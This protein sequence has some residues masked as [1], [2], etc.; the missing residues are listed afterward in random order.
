[1]SQIKFILMCTL[2]F[3]LLSCAETTIHTT[4]PPAALNMNARVAVVSFVNHSEIPLAGEQA[5]TVAA[6]ALSVRGF[7]HVLVS[8]MSEQHHKPP[9][10]KEKARPYKEQLQWARHVGAKY[11]LIGNIKAWDYLAILG[12]KPLI[13]VTLQLIDVAS[14]RTVWTADGSKRGEPRIAVAALTAELIHA[15]LVR[16]CA[17]TPTPQC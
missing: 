16:L 13:G 4:T 12:C 14:G 5:K 7:R 8:P 15:M 10:K 17:S 9:L 6:K 11:M 2:S 1:M 3:L